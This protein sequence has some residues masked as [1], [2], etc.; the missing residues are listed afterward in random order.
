MNL[1]LNP[2]SSRF[3]ISKFKSA[4]NTKCH[5][6]IT[7]DS[8]KKSFLHSWNVLHWLHTISHS[9]LNICCIV[10]GIVH[11]IWMRSWVSNYPH[12]V[13]GIYRYQFKKGKHKQA[14][15]FSHKIQY[16]Y[17]PIYYISFS[18]LV[19][20]FFAGVVEVKIVQSDW[21]FSYIQQS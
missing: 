2:A 4:P 3:V 10:G 13:C 16:I 19:P 7:Y 9:F 8:L 5:Q 11:F 1:F 14:F 12:S 18:R 17:F 20:I 15:S 21:W 6:L